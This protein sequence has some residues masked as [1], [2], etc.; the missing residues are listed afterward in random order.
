MEGRYH[1]S[2]ERLFPLA[3]VGDILTLKIAGNKIVW[4][5]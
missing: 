4:T 1:V 3:N 2:E 5:A